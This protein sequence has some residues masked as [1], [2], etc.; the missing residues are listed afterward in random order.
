VHAFW[1]SLVAFVAHAWIYSYFWT[2]ATIVYLVLRQ[3]V[4]GTPWH[5]IAAPEPRSFEFSVPE[6]TGGSAPPGGPGTPDVAGAD[7]QAAVVAPD[8][9]AHS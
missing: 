6:T 1:L 8:A 7:T 3:D 9:P 2:S 5:K 4:D